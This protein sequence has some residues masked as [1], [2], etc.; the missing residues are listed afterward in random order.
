MG[1]CTAAYMHCCAVS[2]P[3]HGIFEAMGLNL[4][5]WL[6]GL[7]NCWQARRHQL[8]E[9]FHSELAM[10]WSDYEHMFIV[11]ARFR[12]RTAADRSWPQQQQQLLQ[13]APRFL[14]PSVTA[15]CRSAVVSVLLCSSSSL[16]A[17]TQPA[18]QCSSSLQCGWVPAHPQYYQKQHCLSSH[19]H[20]SLNIVLLAV[21]LD[22]LPT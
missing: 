17:A 11:C 19:L 9:C 20:P 22:T 1:I 18:R 10:R 5:Q 21:A 2:V 6:A 3:F 14:A 4:V 16:H 12:A 8:S 15:F 7:F 13:R